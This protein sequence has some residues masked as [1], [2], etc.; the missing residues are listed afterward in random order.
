MFPSS[1]SSTDRLRNQP[2]IL[3]MIEAST[4]GCDQ[5]RHLILTRLDGLPDVSPIEVDLVSAGA[6]DDR[7]F[8]CSLR[9]SDAFG[10]SVHATFASAQDR[11][12]LEGALGRLRHAW[13]GTPLGHAQAERCR[14]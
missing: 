10:R 12:A 9:A 13:G 11:A 2:A 8:Q 6:A 5:A 14:A 1:I 7:F 3:C 4:L